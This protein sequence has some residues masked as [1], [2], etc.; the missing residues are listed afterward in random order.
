M[1]T[2]N[3]EKLANAFVP[4]A[5]PSSLV[6]GAALNEVNRYGKKYGGLWVGG[7]ITATPDGLRFAPNRM[8]IAFHDGLE[9]TYIPLASIRAVSRE[10]GWVTG[11]V[12]VQHKEGE[13]RFRC[14]G[15]KQ[16]AAALSAYVTAL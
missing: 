2:L 5:T 4:N 7:K 10:F 14:F 1:S 15:A 16:V 12:A 6:D 13:F 11:I 3:I 9:S 8:N